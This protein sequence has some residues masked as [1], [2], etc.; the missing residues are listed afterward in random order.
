MRLYA[1]AIENALKV[2]FHPFSAPKSSPIM[3]I[4]HS[5]AT[6]TNKILFSNRRTLNIYTKLCF[7]DLQATRMTL[8]GQ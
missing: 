1:F 2:N 8:T 5:K 6:N 3:G 7:K 4:K